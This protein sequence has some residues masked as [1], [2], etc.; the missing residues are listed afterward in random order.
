MN[1]PGLTQRPS[2]LPGYP[3]FYE[4]VT[5]ALALPGSV[6]G[7]LRVS[8]FLLQYYRHLLCSDGPIIQSSCKELARKHSHRNGHRNGQED[9]DGLRCLHH[10]YCQRVRHPSVGCQHGSHRQYY[11][12]H[13]V[14][15]VVLIIKD[16]HIQAKFGVDLTQ[17]TPNNHARQEQPSRN[18]GSVGHTR[19]EVPEGCE[20]DHL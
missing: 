5:T 10:N 17:P 3:D 19:K 9:V 7:S 2:S 8:K 1:Q 20:C 15:F 11:V 4:L 18:I 13:A 6:Q 14:Y 16:T 12:G